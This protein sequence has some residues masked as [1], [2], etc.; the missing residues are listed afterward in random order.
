MSL[1]N[2]EVLALTKVLVKDNKQ[3]KAVRFCNG[4]FGAGNSNTSPY[5]ADSDYT[6]NLED[7]NGQNIYFKDMLEKY[8]PYGD[9]AKV[10]VYAIVEDVLYLVERK[11]RTGELTVKQITLG[12]SYYVSSS[13]AYDT[14]AD[15]LI[16]PLAEKE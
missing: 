2:E 16:K 8:L 4:T 6:L 7:L 9:D 5:C 11:R 10:A 15:F 1:S 12:N 13:I 3:I 14:Y